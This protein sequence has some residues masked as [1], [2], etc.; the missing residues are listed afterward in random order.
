MN[1]DELKIAVKNIV[2]DGMEEMFNYASARIRQGEYSRASNELCR[3]L[4][5]VAIN[6]AAIVE[7][8]FEF[9][10]PTIWGRIVSLFVQGIA[11]PLPNKGFDSMLIEAE[12]FLDTAGGEGTYAIVLDAVNEIGAEYKDRIYS[13]LLGIEP[14]NNGMASG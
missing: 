12:D 4:L 7:Q 6:K 11:T 8:C 1:P 5:P 14:T 13:E 2:K 10:F 3:P 9:V